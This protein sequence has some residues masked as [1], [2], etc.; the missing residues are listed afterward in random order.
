MNKTSDL[1]H[2]K[3]GKELTKIW[4]DSENLSTELME[5]CPGVLCQ[6]TGKAC[7]RI[8]HRHLIVGKSLTILFFVKE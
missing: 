8:Y 3:P 6:L 2:K 5:Y 7:P 1:L 4:I